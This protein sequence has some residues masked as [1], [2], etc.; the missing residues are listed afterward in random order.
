MLG[1]QVSP[2]S[3]PAIQAYGTT[4]T[5]TIAQNPL[6]PGQRRAGSAGLP[7]ACRVAIL[8]DDGTMLAPQ[9]AGEI[10]VRGPAVFDGYEED[11]DSNRRSFHQGWFR[12]GDV[13]HIDEDGYLF[14]TG[15]LKEIINRGGAKVLPL[16]VDAMLMTQNGV[17][18][19]ACFGVPH[20]TLGEDV[21]AAVV[22]RAG[23]TVSA[24]QLRDALLER[25]AAYK[26]PS[27]IMLV[28]EIPRDA[29]GKVRR[30]ELSAARRTS[31]RPDYVPP[32]GRFQ[33]LVADC[34]RD[35]LGIERIGAHDNF[36]A[37]G[38]DSLRGTQAVARLNAALGLDL[39]A[40]VLFRRP[41]IGELAAALEM[42][43]CSAAPGAPPAL[44]PRSRRSA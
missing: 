33:Q 4:E 28:D 25:M 19:A 23:A 5:S 22:L 7:A 35:V 29:Q 10:V 27:R 34:F 20:P 31:T 3:V 8:G 16:E 12:T 40:A 26:V 42:A 11:D 32:R 41:T 37:L 39:G 18:D 17:A 30:R 9:H 15:R 14:V 13:G 21:V 2:G 43:A 44:T 38:G 6:P 36:F 1:S 24:Q